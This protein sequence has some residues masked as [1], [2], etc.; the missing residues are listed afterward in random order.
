TGTGGVD[1]FDFDDSTGSISGRRRL[2]DIPPEQGAP[3]GMA[4]DAE[5][6]LW[7]ALWG[8]WAVHRYAPDGRRDGV[9]ELPVS[10]VTSCAFGGPDHRDLYISSAS[11]M[12]DDEL[13]AQPHAGGLFRC[14][15]GVTG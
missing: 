3:D 15:S 8:G 5:G 1:V 4:I 14:R 10:Q 6:Y 11:Q 9:V 2:I 13:R 7:V 12:T